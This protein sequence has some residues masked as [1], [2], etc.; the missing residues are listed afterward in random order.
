MEEP[1][2]EVSVRGPRDGFTE[3][4]RINTS[5]FRRRIRSPKLKM[6][7]ITLGQFSQTDIVI[8]YIEGIVSNGILEE[9]RK[10]I[11][12]IQIDGV[13]ESG[14]IEDFIEDTPWSPFPQSSIDP[15]L[16]I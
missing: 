14:Y 10:R 8:S 13:L 15:I 11:G 5:L 2:A 9:V 7:L 12:R 16:L 3:S 6:E 1:A 4:L